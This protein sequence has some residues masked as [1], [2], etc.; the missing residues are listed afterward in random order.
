M[1]DKVSCL[2]AT[3]CYKSELHQVEI[4]AAPLLF[5]ERSK[6]IYFGEKK[7]EFDLQG[8]K[9]RTGTQPKMFSVQNTTIDLQRAKQFDWPIR[10]TDARLQNNKQSTWHLDSNAQNKEMNSG[11]NSRTKVDIRFRGCYPIHQNLSIKP[12]HFLLS[13]W[14]Q[15][16]DVNRILVRGETAPFYFRIREPQP[17][18]NS[19]N[20]RLSRNTH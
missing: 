20:Q 19:W 10:K 8:S 6:G 11:R 12:H 4:F 3:P 17:S 16:S 1:R 15:R 14:Q 7:I 9:L 2:F 18:L 13:A 5:S